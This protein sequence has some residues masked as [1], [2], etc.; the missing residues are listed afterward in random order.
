[1]LSLN[2]WS[3]FSSHIKLHDIA[4]DNVCIWFT[5]FKHFNSS[6]KTTTTKTKFHGTKVAQPRKK[7][8]H[9]ASKKNSSDE[10]EKFYFVYVSSESISTNCVDSFFGCIFSFIMEE[11]S[12]AHE[13]AASEIKTH[14]EL[15]N[16]RLQLPT[17]LSLPL[18]GLSA[19]CIPCA[20][21]DP[22]PTAL[23]VDVFALAPDAKQFG[24]NNLSDPQTRPTRFQSEHHK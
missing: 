22:A 6:L 18:G 16:C 24:V 7:A 15:A 21:E 23:Q 12:N 4:A 11:Q 1:M 20:I 3:C 5:D 8:T 19:L 13:I 9:V 2:L 10:F 17:P 14:L